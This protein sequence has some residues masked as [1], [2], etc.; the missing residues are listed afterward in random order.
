MPPDADFHGKK[1]LLVDDDR[2]NIF[3]ITSVLKGRGLTVLHAENGK[4]GIEL[5]KET[6]M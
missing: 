2:R 4:E 6:R 1:V 5:L 3:A